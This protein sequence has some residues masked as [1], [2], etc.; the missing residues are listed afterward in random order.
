M[1]DL[2]DPLVLDI[3]YDH[4]YLKQQEYLREVTMQRYNRRE[5]Y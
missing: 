3:T 1:L 2:G 5:E 4:N